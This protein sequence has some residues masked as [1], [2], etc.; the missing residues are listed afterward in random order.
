M[1]SGKMAGHNASGSED[2]A[3]VAIAVHELPIKIHCARHALKCA[4][5]GEGGIQ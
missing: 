1:K 2:A 3:A 4:H 5:D